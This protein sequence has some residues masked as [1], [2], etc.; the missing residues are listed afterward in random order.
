MVEYLLM[1]GDFL[2]RV[3]GFPLKQI[4]ASKKT[5]LAA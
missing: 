2:K 1:G 5:G 3:H 4:T